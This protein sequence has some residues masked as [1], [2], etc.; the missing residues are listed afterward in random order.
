M[1]LGWSSCLIL[2]PE[3]VSST[4]T[5]T[6]SASAHAIRG[7]IELDDIVALVDG[8][9]WRVVTVIHVED[10][11]ALDALCEVEPASSERRARS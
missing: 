6:T 4:P 3:C 11:A 8:L 1:L 5:A 10:S 2:G 7:L 9:P